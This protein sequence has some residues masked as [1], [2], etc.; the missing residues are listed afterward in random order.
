LADLFN[1]NGPDSV[2]KECDPMKR[3]LVANYFLR[4][5][6][7]TVTA[8][9]GA[10]LGPDLF[11]QVQYQYA[12]E[13]LATG[14]IVRQGRMPATGLPPNELFLSPNTR[15]RAWFLRND[16]LE[17]GQADFSTPDAGSFFSIPA[18]QVGLPRTPDLDG[19]GLSTEAEFI[20]GTNPLVSDSN[21][22]GIADGT[23]VRLGIEA[24]GIRTGVVGSVATSGNALDVAAFNDV[25]VVADEGFGVSVFNI[26]NRMIPLQ[27]AQVDT[28]GIAL[29]VACGLNVV[30]V[31]DGPAGLAI[32]DIRR[33]EQASIVHQINLGGE[34]RAVAISGSFAFAGLQG[35]QVAVVDM[36]SGEVLER[37][38]HSEAVND[39][40]VEGDVLFVLLG[41]QLIA[42]EMDDGSLT[43]AGSASPSLFAEGITASR[44]L[45]V[46]GGIAYVTAYPGFDTYSVSDPQNI[47]QLGSATDQGP[48]SFK[49]I[50]ANGSGLG[51][52]AVGANPRDDGTHDVYLYNIAD[53]ALTTVFETQFPTP[54]LARAV[55][56]YNGFAYVADSSAGLQVINY[57][58]VDAQGQ[59]PTIMLFTSA[60]TNVVEE[61]K[62][63]RVWAQV[64]DDVQVRNVE[65]YL[66]G[67]RVV[68]DGNF[69]FEARLVAPLLNSG[70][71]AFR[72]QARAS[73]TGGN[74]TSSAE[75]SFELRRDGTPPRVRGTLPNRG[76]FVAEISLLGAYFSEP[77]DSANLPANALRIE[78]FGPDGIPGT[79]DDAPVNGGTIEYQ[80]DRNAV[81][82]R[83]PGALP[84]G[85]YELIAAAGIA[86]LAGNRTSVESKSRFYVI[87]GQDTDQD[88]VPDAIEVALGLDPNNP[89]S[90]SPGI[91]DSQLDLDSDG[92]PTGWELVSGLDPSK[93]DSDS[94]GILDGD[95]DEDFDG[96]GFAAEYRQGT[97]PKT[98][99][100]DGDGWDDATEIAEG[101]DPLAADSGARI[102]LSTGSINYLNGHAPSIPEAITYTLA[103]AQI[104][105]LNGLSELPPISVPS[106]VFSLPV[107][108]INA[109][110][111]QLPAEIP[112]SLASSEVAYLNALLEAPPN[113]VTYLLA[114][115]QVSYLNARLDPMPESVP[116]YLFSGVVAYRQVDPNPSALKPPATPQPLQR[117][118][119]NV[120]DSPK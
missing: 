50:V 63:F 29:R 3:N 78:F 70:K 112:I 108:F 39:L 57:K 67:R 93:Q 13:N 94:D 74:S 2:G 82:L 4:R 11:A 8:V 43:R 106:L 45:F 104:G 89:F 80:A 55:T 69:P 49:H 105:Y 1:I 61:G 51:V 12:I 100:S 87:G 75:L 96:L 6:L 17:V 103:S 60:T 88:G 109:L 66:D 72:L 10:F 47:R 115:T 52:A 73:D 42:Y 22:D 35:G 102:V 7:I 58:P 26:F 16:T 107:S 111:E 30:A 118:I 37:V 54:G 59:P 85:G 68:T 81:L 46:G 41:S 76:A 40:G 91:L 53:P 71:S 99:D 62:S 79:T 92:L 18:I 24:G 33:P 36:L 56:I 77:L 32:I 34:V 28:P 15:Y 120:S 64:G 21:G 20:V 25:V 86:D 44:R 27:I 48:N 97:S 83:I 101:T 9:A 114:S 14:Q 5:V 19:D 65:F 117:P 31:A 38:N 95:E 110:I 84:A 113:D 23:A 119:S 116:D 98:A 90:R